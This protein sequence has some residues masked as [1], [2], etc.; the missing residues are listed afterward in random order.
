MVVQNLL[1][2]HLNLIMMGC[3]RSAVDRMSLMLNLNNGK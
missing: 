1:T 3:N 2:I